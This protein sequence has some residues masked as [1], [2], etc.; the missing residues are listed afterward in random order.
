[1]PSPAIAEDVKGSKGAGAGRFG[2]VVVVESAVVP[3]CALGFIDDPFEAGKGFA[4]LPAS[5]S[6]DAAAQLEN[7]S[8]E[9]PMSKNARNAAGLYMSFSP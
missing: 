9:A 7:S 2:I 3:G 8:A 6:D 5:V 1:M 4:V